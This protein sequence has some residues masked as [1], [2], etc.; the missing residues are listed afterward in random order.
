MVNKL[1]RVADKKSFQRIN[2]AGCPFVSEAQKNYAPVRPSLS[3][4]PLA[5]VFIVRNQDTILG[6]CPLY[7][8]LIFYPTCFLKYREDIVLMF[9]QPPCDGRASTFIYKETHSGCLHQ[10]HKGHAFHRFSCEQ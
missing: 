7:N 3:E 4:D 8:L 1:I 6:E 5:K 9:S 10:R 2:L